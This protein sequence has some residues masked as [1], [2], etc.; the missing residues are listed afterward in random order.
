MDVSQKRKFGRVPREVTVMGFGAAPIGNLFCP[1]SEQESSAEMAWIATEG[2]AFNHATDRVADIEA[3]AAAQRRLG[4]PIKDEVEVSA[5]GRVRQTAFRAAIVEREFI[6]DDGA[7]ARRA[8]PGSFHEIISRA[9]VVDDQGVERLDLSFD[10]GDAQQIFRMT[11]A[12]PAPAPAS[13]PTDA[14]CWQVL[15]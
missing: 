2:Q 1:I 8:V 5:S 12:Q 10:S 14:A 13:V 3:V 4:R 6:A 7:T 9:R 15:G 11:A